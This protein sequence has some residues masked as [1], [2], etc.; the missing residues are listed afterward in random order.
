MATCEVVH[1]L[2]FGRVLSVGSP[3]QIQSD[4]GVLDAYLG[5]GS[6]A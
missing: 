3:E 2:H 1:V 5:Q 6:R 4:Q